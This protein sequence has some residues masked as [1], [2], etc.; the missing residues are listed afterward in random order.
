MSDPLGCSLEGPERILL[1][2]QMP[3][4]DSDPNLYLA[5]WEAGCQPGFPMWT[6][7]RLTF[8]RSVTPSTWEAMWTP[9]F[10]P[11]IFRGWISTNSIPLKVPAATAEANSG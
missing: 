2:K 5:T 11:L 1:E 10:F 4:H 6:H 3:H 8:P 9:A 7:A